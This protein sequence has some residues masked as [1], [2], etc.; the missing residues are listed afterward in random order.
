M[1]KYLKYFTSV[2]SHNRVLV[3]WLLWPF[4]FNYN[5]KEIRFESWRNNTLNNVLFVNF[6]SMIKLICT[7]ELFYFEIVNKNYFGYKI[8][9]K[10][11]GLL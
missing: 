5:F 3:Q 8:L 4:K 6:M 9:S 1:S 2:S 7:F 10:V 11:V